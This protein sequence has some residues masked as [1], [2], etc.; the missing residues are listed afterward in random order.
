MPATQQRNDERLCGITRKTLANSDATLFAGVA[1]TRGSGPDGGALPR[2]G[3]ARSARPAL[4][5]TGYVI[6]AELDPA[7]HTPDRQGRGRLIPPP[8]Q[9]VV[10]FGFH[11]ALKVT[12]ITDESGK[13]A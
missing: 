9:D 6:D 10:S 5:I 8:N 2:S 3:P 12:N 13:T 11:P 1:G 4:N 7:T